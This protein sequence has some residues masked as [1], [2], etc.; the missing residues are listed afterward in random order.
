MELHYIVIFTVILNSL[1]W[2]WYI[3]NTLKWK[4][5]PNKITW[6]IWAAA[7]LIWSAATISS[8]WFIWA[9]LPVFMAGFIPLMIFLASFI[10]KKSYWKLWKLDYWCLALAVLALLLWFIT[11]QPLLA[12]IFWVLAD[13]LAA[14]PLLIKIHKYPETETIWPF[15]TLLIAN[16]SAFL[17][18][19]NWVL[20]EYL[21]PLYLVIICSIIIL[22]YYSK[23]LLNIK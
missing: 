14:I 9:V 5:K 23:R 3:I 19:Q 11:E 22:A 8:Q 4:T 21:F 20:E 16:A 2:I 6:W 15:I 17:V 13:L 1:W 7:P 18:I 10:S 12:I